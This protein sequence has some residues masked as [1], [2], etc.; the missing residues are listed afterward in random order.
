MLRGFHYIVIIFLFIINISV[1]FAFP[2]NFSLDALQAVVSDMQ[3][4]VANAESFPEKRDILKKL[5]DIRKKSLMP[6]EGLKNITG[7]FG[8]SCIIANFRATGCD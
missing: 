3:K 1:A 5:N 8:S 2:D 6:A 4:T 7:F